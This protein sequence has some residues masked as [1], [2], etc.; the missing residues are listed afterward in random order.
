MSDNNSPVG[1][2]TM[3]ESLYQLAVS[4]PLPA[5]TLD[6]LPPEIIL[7]IFYKVS[8]RAR[9]SCNVYSLATTSRYMYSVFKG[10]ELVILRNIIFENVYSPDIKIF[11]DM[12]IRMGYLRTLKPWPV[13][14]AD[15]YRLLSEPIDLTQIP[16]QKY[17][18]ILKFARTTLRRTAFEPHKKAFAEWWSD[19]YDQSVD[20]QLPAPT[21]WAM[22]HPY[23]LFAY[24]FTLRDRMNSE[25]KPWHFAHILTVGLEKYWRHVNTPMPEAE[26][27]L[28]G[29]EGYVPC[30]M[31]DSC[32]RHLGLAART[33]PFKAW[34]RTVKRERYVILG[35]LY[36]KGPSQRELMPWRE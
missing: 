17:G 26:R 6:E 4:P 23:D 11:A 34:D 21:T 13:D 25:L 28:V 14:P 20:H 9:S 19:R 30:C 32:P 18:A 29:T 24:P 5:V 15:L 16:R 31:V 8:H 7:K 22:F 3:S 33:C 1:L 27:A 35:L 10:N 2:D 36:L 12:V